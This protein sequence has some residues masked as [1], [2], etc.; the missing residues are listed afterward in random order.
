MKMEIEVN[1]LYDAY[2][3]STEWKVGDILQDI[4][5]TITNY[6]TKSGMIRDANGNT[7]GSWRIFFDIG[8]PRW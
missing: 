4:C 6:K 7:A 5:E 1:L 8:E 3:D 2:Q